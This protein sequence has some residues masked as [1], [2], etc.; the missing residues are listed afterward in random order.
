MHQIKFGPING[1]FENIC[2][3]YQKGAKKPWQ[4]YEVLN[5]LVPL[6][7]QK[8]CNLKRLSLPIIKFAIT[9]LSSLHVNVV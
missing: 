1:A 3:E 7:L 5:Y 2:C 4:R 6:F 8:W 9:S